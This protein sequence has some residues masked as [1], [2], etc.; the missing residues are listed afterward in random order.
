M[1]LMANRCGPTLVKLY[2]QVI[3]QQKVDHLVAEV[4]DSFV[5][6]RK[7]SF[8]GIFSNLF[9]LEVVQRLIEELRRGGFYRPRL[10]RLKRFSTEKKISEDLFPRIE[11]QPDFVFVE[12]PRKFR[13]KKLSLS[14]TVVERALPRFLVRLERAGSRLGSGSKARAEKLGLR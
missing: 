9:E 4:E 5:R 10:F 11:R 12:R 6:I 8:E 13:K 3:R 7:E 1:S 2:S 14:G